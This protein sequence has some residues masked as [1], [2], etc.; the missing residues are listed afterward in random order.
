MT[1]LPITTLQRWRDNAARVAEHAEAIRLDISR[2][3]AGRENSELL[4]SYAGEC[5]V[6]ARE[7]VFELDRLMD[8][9][10]LERVKEKLKSGPTETLKS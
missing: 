9:H 2:R 3:A 1:R 5:K 10:A 8:L 4:K 6:A 7:M